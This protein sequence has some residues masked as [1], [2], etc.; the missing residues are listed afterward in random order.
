MENAKVLQMK[1]RKCGRG[2]RG[3]PHGPYY[4][5]AQRVAG[6]VKWTYI[7]KSPPAGSVLPGGERFEFDF[8]RTTPPAAGLD[9]VAELPAPAV[10]APQIVELPGLSFF[11]AADLLCVP[12]DQEMPSREVLRK[13]VWNRCKAKKTGPE[14][15]AKLKEALEVVTLWLNDREL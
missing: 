12:I 6:K 7:G 11:E 9:Q 4:Y 5:W 14:L 8:A 2:C 3:C 1:Y 10:A 13:R 15:A